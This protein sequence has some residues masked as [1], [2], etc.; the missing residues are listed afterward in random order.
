MRIIGSI[1]PPD[2]THT[3]N[4]VSVSTISEITDFN[5]ITLHGL[6]VLYSRLILKR[7]SDKNSD[8]EETNNSHSVLSG[9][10]SFADEISST[11]SRQLKR[12]IDQTN[13]IAFKSLDDTVLEIIKK[14][15]TQESEG[16]TIQDIIHELSQRGIIEDEYSIKYL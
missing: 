14:H 12:G 8:S 6:E 7:L 9:T 10:T 13:R 5:E 16:A 1:H 2:A 15:T 4:S 11:I 3:Q